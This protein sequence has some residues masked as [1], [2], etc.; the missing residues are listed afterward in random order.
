MHVDPGQL[1]YAA[2]FA[3]AIALTSSR[4]KF[5]TPGGSIAQFFLGWALLGLGGWKWT[6]PILVFFVSSSLM[7]RIAHQRKRDIED[8]YAKSGSRDAGQV[9]ANGGVAGI[10]VI[11]NVVAP[12]QI[13]YPMSLGAIAAAT[14][15]TWGTEAGILSRTPP[16]LISTFAV[17]EP[18]TSG[19]VT[20]LGSLAGGLGAS[21]IALS[22][23]I[24]WSGGSG[25]LLV[26][27]LSTAGMIASLVDSLLGV[28][29]QSKYRCPACLKVTEK[30]IHCGR[31]GD[32]IGGHRWMTNDLVNLLCTG[33]GAVLAFLAVE[34]AL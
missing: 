29:L 23:L 14:A 26:L 25:A 16:I 22:G 10:L 30:A 11:L 9:L 20:L 28:S 2:V 18:G 21:I 24:W 3:A 17:V 27:A 1:L 7:S 34:L 4:L 33:T 31:S 32:L 5:L 12:L 19:A 6:V 8:H 13:W 15:D